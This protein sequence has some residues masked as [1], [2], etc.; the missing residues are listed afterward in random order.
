M[1]EKFQ[2]KGIKVALM[3][4]RAPPNMGADYVAAFDAI[5]PALANE[6]PNSAIPFL[7]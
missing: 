7:P 4:M 1:I 5:Y 3:G 2:Q 6:L